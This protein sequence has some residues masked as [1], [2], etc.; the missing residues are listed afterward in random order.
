MFRRQQFI[1]GSY[2][3]RGCIFTN[4]SLIVFR[5]LRS[6]I[7]NIQNLHIHRDCRNL[8][9]IVCKLNKQNKIKKVNAVFPGKVMK[10]ALRL[11]GILLL[12]VNKS[13]LKTVSPYN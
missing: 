11:C 2:L 3:P 7:I 8:L 5:E 9:Y 10:T 12:Y 4:E 1:M 6:V 13:Y